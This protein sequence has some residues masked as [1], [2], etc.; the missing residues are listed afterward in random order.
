MIDSYENFLIKSIITLE[1]KEIDESLSRHQRRK[2]NWQLLAFKS[3]LKK[4]RTYL[5]N[6]GR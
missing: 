3:C 4:Y 1:E 2:F 5:K 6:R